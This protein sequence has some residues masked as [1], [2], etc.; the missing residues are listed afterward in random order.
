MEKTC[1]QLIPYIMNELNSMERIQFEKH[2]T[3]CK[4]CQEDYKSVSE[5]V[6]ALPY[7]A[8]VQAPPADLAEQVMT[9]V[10]SEEQKKEPKQIPLFKKWI[11][12]SYSIASVALVLILLT[13]N[14]W[15]WWDQQAMKEAPS[16]TM[17][18]EII[19]T[20]SLTSTDGSNP[21]ANGKVFLVRKNGQEQIIA[22]ISQMAPTTGN[23]VYQVWLLQG[24]QRINAGTMNVD[25]QGNGAL[26]F[27][28]PDHIG[29]DGIG[30]TLEPDS[31]GD[32]PRGKKVLGS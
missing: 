24:N 27:H 14:L 8:E 18:G 29:F 10:F 16:I 30:I 2:L 12:S 1:E 3:Q 7:S 21:K 23:E 11:R 15:L 31:L 6:S 22:S 17:P 9:V 26:V 20:W 13:S 5:T 25:Q 28:L 32:T 19:H 4:T